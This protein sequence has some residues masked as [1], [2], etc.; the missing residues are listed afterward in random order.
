MRLLPNQ[1]TP[2]PIAGEGPIPQR[3]CFRGAPKDAHDGLCLLSVALSLYCL[4]FSAGMTI[5]GIH[6]SLSLRVLALDALLNA[7]AIPIV[8]IAAAAILPRDARTGSLSA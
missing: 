1:A 6:E 2:R 7:L 5:W 4:V 8:A 3:V